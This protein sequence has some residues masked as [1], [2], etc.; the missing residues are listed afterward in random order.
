[1]AITDP[2]VVRLLA[3]GACLQIHGHKEPDGSWRFIGTAMNLDILD[4]G[5]DAVRV[6][7]IPWCRELSE[8]LPETA[9][10]KFQPMLIHPEL[11]GWFR[12]RYEAAKATLPEVRCGDEHDELFATLRE[13]RLRKWESVFASTPPDRWC[14]EDAI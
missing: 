7:G 6:G 2:P 4:D 9:W 3:E 10:I 8:A 13:C 11:R 5:N 12:D 1:M 14:A